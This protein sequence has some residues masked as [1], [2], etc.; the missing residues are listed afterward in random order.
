MT[1]LACTGCSLTWL[2]VQADLALHERMEQRMMAK[3]RAAEQALLDGEFSILNSSPL[4]RAQVERFAALNARIEELESM[5]GLAP[6]KVLPP[7]GPHQSM[8]WL[9][10]PRCICLS[11]ILIILSVLCASPARRKELCKG[12][13]WGP[14][15]P[16]II[17][18]CPPPVD[19]TCRLH[20]AGR[21]TREICSFHTPVSPSLAV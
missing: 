1:G 20:A 7:S 8:Q 15:S 9:S 12:L 11:I 14:A 16:V 3:V 5:R 18:A 10:K 4:G 13:R 17:F 2:R 21:R 6:A 19:S